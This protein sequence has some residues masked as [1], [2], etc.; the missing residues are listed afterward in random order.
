MVDVFIDRQTNGTPPTFAWL[1]LLSNPNGASTFLLSQ[2]GCSLHPTLSVARCA[3][4]E[5]VWRYVSTDSV[6]RP[7]I[8]TGTS[9]G[10]DCAAA[11]AATLFLFNLRRLLTYETMRL[12][13]TKNRDPFIDTTNRVS[14]G[15]K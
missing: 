10:L 13:R 14:S 2:H 15:Y 8:V 9:A 12:H 6:L 4:C 3:V 11:T 5:V 1:Q 7:L